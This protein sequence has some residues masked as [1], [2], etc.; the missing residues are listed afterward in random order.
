[1]DCPVGQMGP[2]ITRTDPRWLKL[3]NNYQVT[4]NYPDKITWIALAA[5]TKLLIGWSPTRQMQKRSNGSFGITVP[6]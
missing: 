6:I 4:R 1:M 2:E 5:L 3:S